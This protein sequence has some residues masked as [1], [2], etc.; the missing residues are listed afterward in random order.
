MGNTVRFGTALVYPSAMIQIITTQDQHTTD[1][2]TL[3][4]SSEQ[5]VPLVGGIGA[6]SAHL[7]KQR[8]QQ[9]QRQKYNALF[10]IT[11]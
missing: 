2:K 7:Q 6:G 11:L 8:M 9:Q 10:G 5:K 4:P 3:A 1:H